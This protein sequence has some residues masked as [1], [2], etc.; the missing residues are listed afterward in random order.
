MPGHVVC[1]GQVEEL[2]GSL[3]VHGHGVVVGVLLEQGLQ[4]RCDVGAMLDQARR[5]D[6]RGYHG[7]VAS[8]HCSCSPRIAV[9]MRGRG[10][11]PCPD[12]MPQAYGAGMGSVHASWPGRCRP[13][14]RIHWPGADS[15]ARQNASFG[16]GSNG[17]QPTG[18]GAHQADIL[19]R[20]ARTRLL[21]VMIFPPGHVLS[22]LSSRAAAGSG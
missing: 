8:L 16:C 7:G 20:Y 12:R 15:A 19:H 6:D 17:K 18:S 14:G 4:R 21:S 1:L 22:W 13:Y 11:L 9:R 3:P 10:L 5:A 2:P